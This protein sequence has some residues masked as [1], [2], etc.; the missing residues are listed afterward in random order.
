LYFGR[1]FLSHSFQK[2]TLRILHASFG[3]CFF[4]VV[5]SK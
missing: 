5:L 2:R 4:E 3:Y 1:Y